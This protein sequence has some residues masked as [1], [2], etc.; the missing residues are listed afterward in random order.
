MLFQNSLDPLAS[1]S[2]WDSLTFLG[3]RTTDT[4]FTVRQMQ[5]KYGSKGNKLYFACRSEKKA[6]DRVTYL[7]GL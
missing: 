1:V 7:D 3:K 2:A 5:Q 6:F 4:L